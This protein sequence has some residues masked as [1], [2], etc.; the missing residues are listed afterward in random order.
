M[1]LGE[2]FQTCCLGSFCLKF[3]HRVTADKTELKQSFRENQREETMTRSIVT[4]LLRTEEH[5]PGECDISTRTSDK[6]GTVS[7]GPRCSNT[8]QQ[9][10]QPVV[11]AHIQIHVCRRRENVHHFRLK[12]KHEYFIKTFG[13]V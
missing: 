12:R 6:K 10:T 5:S 2:F 1:F 11:T 13:S 7:R 3:S 4:G 8:S 9:R